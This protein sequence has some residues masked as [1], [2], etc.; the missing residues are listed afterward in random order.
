MPWQEQS[1]MS[2]RAEF[3]QLVNQGGISF[4]ETCRRF[5]ISRPTGYKWWSR[6]LQH[7]LDGLADQSRRP[8]QSPHQTET[9]MEAAVLA[10]RDQHPTWGGR[11]L[12]TV[13]R[14][15]GWSSVPSAST[16]T[17]ILRRHDR[18]DPDRTHSRGP[19]QRFV[20]PQPNDLWQLDFKGH[21]SLVEGRCHPLTVLDDH[22][23]YVLG[24]FACANE[25]EPTVRSHLTSLFQRYGLPQRI[26][27]DNS[28]PWGSTQPAQPLTLLSIWLL[29]L[30][31]D[32]RHGRFY[33]PQT[34]GKVERVHRTIKADLL[35][36]HRYPSLA[37]AQ[38]AFAE[39]RQTYNQLRPHDAL[40]L[41]VPATR[42]QCSPRPFPDPLPPL[43]YDDADIVRVVRQAGEISY[44]GQ[45]Y[46]LSLALRGQPVAL[47]PTLVDGVYAVHFAQYQMGEL[48]LHDKRFTMHYGV[49]S[50]V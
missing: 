1:I 11:K 30:G 32:V 9:A 36:Q 35:Q 23:R 16:I 8:R 38:A 14:R 37:S 25:Q 18:L 17:E 7:G 24:L 47:R 5:G 27:T 4:A 3:V 22:S 15:Q 43:E 40:E 12:R 34:Q 20:Y 26:L 41:A 49:Q 39:W 28:G 19:W 6:Y 46:R 21:F 10:L 48:N 45:R 42:Y 29:R 13:L 33:H 44:R 2:L 31:I 50:N